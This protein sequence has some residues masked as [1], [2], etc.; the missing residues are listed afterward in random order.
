MKVSGFCSLVGDFPTGNTELA[1]YVFPE[2]WGEGLKRLANN[3]ATVQ[4][5][6]VWLFSLNHAYN[7]YT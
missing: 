5:L 3:Y 2:R 7:N 4:M 1:N 6:R